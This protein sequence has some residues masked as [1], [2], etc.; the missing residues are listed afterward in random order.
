MRYVLGGQ[1]S[2]K[3]IATVTPTLFDDFLIISLSKKWIDV[4]KKIPEFS[5]YVDKNK[6]LII[7]TVGDKRSGDVVSEQDERD[8][9][10]KDLL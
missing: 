3:K 9:K 1:T 4:W 10:K 2:L 6:Q 8:N 7:K 5:V